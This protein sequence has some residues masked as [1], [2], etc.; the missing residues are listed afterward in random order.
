M[1]RNTGTDTLAAGTPKVKHAMNA[2]DDSDGVVKLIPDEYF[3]PNGCRSK[4]TI[5]ECTTLFEY[6]V[7]RGVGMIRFSSVLATRTCREELGDRLVAKYAAVA[8]GAYEIVSSEWVRTTDPGRAAVP[9]T[10]PFR[11]RHFLIALADFGVLE[12]LADDAE[13]LGFRA[14]DV[15]LPHEMGRP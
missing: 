7:E 10:T 6:E 8:S 14:G 12:V 9:R 1:R 5:T 11:V 13:F 15:E 3:P 2:I 4:V